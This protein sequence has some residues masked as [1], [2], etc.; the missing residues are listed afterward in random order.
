MKDF[1]KE[2]SGVADAAS[3][4]M[5]EA[6]KGQQHKIDKNKNNK[7]DA[8]DFAILRGEKKAPMK[9]EEVQQIDELVGKGKLPA[10]AAYHKQKSVEAK[11]K[12][13]T[14]RNTNTK[15]PVPKAMSAKVYAKDAESKYHSTQA[16]RADAL[17][18][19]EEVQQIDEMGYSAKAARAGKDIGKPGKMFAKI[20][21]SAA[22]KYGSEERGKKVAGAVLAKLRMKEDLDYDISDELVDLMLEYE[23]KDGVYK[24][25]G[26]YGT[27]KGADYGD[28]DWDKEEK[29]SKKMTDKKPKKMGARQNY[30]RSRKVSGKVLE[31]FT[32]MLNAYQQDGLKS[33][34]TP[35]E[36]VEEEKQEEETI[37]VEVTDVNAIN[38]VAVETIEE[39]TLTEPETA[40]KEEIV[41]SMKKKM[42]GFKQR[43]GENAKSVMYATA[44]KMAKKGA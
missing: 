17:M 4:I 1:K 39:R 44:T 5:G 29:E 8:H 30:I 28:T 42:S 33:L 23:S 16:K 31:S 6:L 26:T 14:V 37:Q 2:L 20:A 9:K 34:Y 18:K 40:K 35:V 25:K 27:E 43:Y 11:D 38:G 10:I 21:S 22:K 7:I 41:K 36:V 3:K 32:G 12:M 19:K 15:L 24:H 13:E